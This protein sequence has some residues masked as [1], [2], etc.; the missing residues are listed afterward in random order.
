MND[1]FGPES[2]QD[3]MR[4]GF[5]RRD[6]GRL[7]ALMT[8]GATLPFYNEAV[9]AQGLSAMPNLPPDAV[10]INA[11]ENPMGPCPEAADAIH[12]VVSQGGRYLYNETSAFVAAMAEVDAVPTDH[13]MPFAG[14]SDPLHR[15]VLAFTGPGK[16]Y[17]VADPGY[18]AG[19]RAAHFIG[20]KTISVP[21]RKDYA[22]DV[23]A[24]AQ[25]DPEAGLIYVCNPNNPTGSITPKEDIEYLIAHKPKDAIVLLDEAYI[26]L[27]K[28]AKPASSLVAADKDVIILRT[29][30][31]LYGMAGL[32]AGAALGRPDLLAKLRNYGAGALPVTG[33]VAAIASLKAKGL[34]EQRRKTIADVR[35]ETVEWLDK[36]GFSVLP[37]EAN[38]IM[39]DVR[40]PGRQVFQAL[41]N[42]KVVIGRTWPSMPQHVRVSIGTRD[43]MTKF[44]AAFGHV[45]NV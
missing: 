24:M 10:K 6:F 29:F 23:H 4:R 12:K 42:E 14:S 11:N 30:S 21:L 5:S 27:S 38:M 28:N 7:A 9:L 17:V 34:V 25:A 8:A 13:V 18:E 33:M 45:M 31:K 43:E 32:R 19:A 36:K 37:S 35:E 1:L 41:L 26:H 39:V 15:A 2:R 16:S 3:L 40:R 44:R 22:H 20:A